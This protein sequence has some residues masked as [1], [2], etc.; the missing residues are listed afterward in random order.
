MNDAPLSNVAARDVN[1]VLH[2]YTNLVTHEKVGP[3][4]LESGEGI[5]VTDS[6]GK[7]YIEGMSGLWCTSLGFG[8]QELQAAAAE[9]MAKLPYSHLFAGRSHDPAIELSE[10]LKDLVPMDASKILFMGSGSEANDAQ[11]KLIWYYN[12]ALGRPEKKKIISRMRA[13]HGVTIAAGSLTGL[14][15]VH[16]DFDL[17]I[18]GI[19]HTDCPDFYRD[20][21][22]G[23][24]EQE[25][26]TRLAEGLDE[27]ITR[28]D[29]DTVAAFIAEPVM[30]A[31]GV[32]LPPET[33]FSKV[34]EVLRRHDV[35]LIDDEVICG[36]GRTGNMFGAETFDMAPDTVSM[37]KGLSSAYLPIGAIAVPEFMYEAFKSESEKLGTFGH[38]S[39]YGGH[40]VCAAVALK[41]LDIME[42]RSLLDHIN[43][44]SGQ[45]AARI[46]GF[47]DHPMVGNT[48][49]TGLLGAVELAVGVDRYEP[50]PATAGVGA[51][52]MGEALEEGL[53]QRA[54][55]DIVAF[56]PPLIITESE[57]DELFDRFGR[58]LEKTEA[59]A[60]KEGL[61]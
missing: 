46:D 11:I 45:F 31:G 56:C 25:F 14:P 47:K 40:P 3:L 37:A 20:A 9:Q 23:E 30:G 8:D 28:E 22:P 38:G 39:T 59:W 29:P 21:E 32:V 43:S 7:Q 36:F 54:M 41:V 60:S 15:Y 58:A 13:Y 57:I 18:K 49:A 12:N 1:A 4:I 55:G 52:F 24:S 27:L 51:H 6:H 53:I 44:V 19:L 16:E 50:F 48:R 61:L 42:E 17:P 10:R 35:L 34:Q 26:A 2:P 5:Y 33:Y